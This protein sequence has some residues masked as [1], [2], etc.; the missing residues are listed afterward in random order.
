M[1]FMIIK[2]KG[3]QEN[4]EIKRRY[5]DGYREFAGVKFMEKFAPTISTLAVDYLRR[6]N[7][8]KTIPT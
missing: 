7:F 1:G 3:G 8:T 6:L 4:P 5:K 2:I